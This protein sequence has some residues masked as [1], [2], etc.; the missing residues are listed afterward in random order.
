MACD[1]ISTYNTGYLSLLPH[2]APSTIQAPDVGRQVSQPTGT[3]T[4]TLERGVG[5]DGT[6]GMRNGDKK[7]SEQVSGN[8]AKTTC[9]QAEKNH[10]TETGSQ[11]NDK[12]TSH[13]KPTA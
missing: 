9:L 1:G 13:Q 11:G 3:S 2:G 4:E 7:Y 8:Q 12:Q 10:T 6:R 5:K